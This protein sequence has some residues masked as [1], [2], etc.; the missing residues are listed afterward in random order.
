MY[1]DL[2]DAD[3]VFVT[4]SLMGI[5][6]VNKIE[7]ITYGESSVLDNIINKYNDAIH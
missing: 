3:E 7:D 2:K 4:N 6:R 5:M 1:E